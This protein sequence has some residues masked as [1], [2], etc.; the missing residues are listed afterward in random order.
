MM[1]LWVKRREGFSV[2]TAKL[3]SACLVLFVTLT[4]PQ[5]TVRCMLL[6]ME[7]KQRAWGYASQQITS[8]VPQF[9]VRSSE[10]RSIK[11]K[12]VVDNK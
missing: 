2:R 10:W 3:L 11:P 6:G 5:L 12:I 9:L 1:N 4:L 8:F 7:P